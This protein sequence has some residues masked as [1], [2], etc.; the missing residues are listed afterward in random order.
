MP[1]RPKSVKSMPLSVCKW[2]PNAARAPIQTST[3][4]RDGR[5]VQRPGP[6]GSAHHCREIALADRRLRIAGYL[7]IHVA[8]ARRDANVAGD[9]GD[10]DV[11]ARVSRRPS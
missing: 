8:A 7:D 4:P 2:T 11:A 9:V 1:R 3:S 5:K 10:V 6:L